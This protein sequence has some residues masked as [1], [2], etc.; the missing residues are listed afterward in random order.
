MQEADKLTLGQNIT[1]LVS[2]QV[3]SL[4]NGTASWWM[5][6]EQVARY[7]ALLGENPQV[8]VKVMRALNP[9]KYLPGGGAPPLL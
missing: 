1:L 3:T 8:R 9:A 4:L 7:Q 2:H 6:G 5:T